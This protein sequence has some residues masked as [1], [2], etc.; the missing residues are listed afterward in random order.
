MNGGPAPFD[1][2]LAELER[3]IRALEQRMSAVEARSGSA[4]DGEASDTT[5]AELDLNAVT[6]A[7][8]PVAILSL[9]GRTLVVLGG[10][11]LLRALTESQVLTPSIGVLVG[12]IYGMTWLAIADR[13]P[14][15]AWLSAIFHGATSVMIALPLL[16]EAVTRF[17]ILGAVPA[18]WILAA[19]T[20][21][22]LA[23]AIRCRLQTLAWITIVGAIASS[24]ALT[25]ATSSVLPFAVVDIALG[26]A[27]LWIGYTVDWVWLRWPVALVTDFAVMAL[28]IGITSRTSS[29][30]PSS[31]VAVQLL[32]PGAYAL[33]VAIRTLVRGREV[34]VFEA[35]QVIVA[36]A[37]GFGGAIIVA[38]TAG[39]GGGLLVAM[40]LISGA[41]C[42]AAA[43]AFVARRQGLHQNFY[44][45]S[46]LGLV[47]ILAGSA[48]GLR[49]AAPLWALLAVF[50]AFAATRAHRVTL[51][52]HAAA[53]YLAAAAASGLLAAAATAL[54]GPP[55]TQP[56]ASVPLAI[57]F[58]AGCV[59]WLVPARVPQ[60][61]SDRRA[62]VPRV[63]IAVIV[64]LASAG[65]LVALLV[66]NA[67]DP[68]VVATIRTGALAF[69]ALAL[70]WLGGA[71]RFREAAWLV[72]PILVLGAV[73]LLAE[74]LPRSRAA[75]LFVALAVYGGA[76]IAAPRSCTTRL[77][78]L[79]IPVGT[80][81]LFITHL[82]SD[83]TIGIPDLW[84][85]AFLTNPYGG[86]NDAFRVWGPA[87][88]TAMMADMRKAYDADIQIRLPKQGVDIDAK[89]IT[90]GAGG[91][92]GRGP[93]Y[94][95]PAT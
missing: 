9:V 10:A 57:V 91:R 27:T 66:S 29:A 73:K 38:R 12:F 56:T 62:R 54:V 88:I 67:T 55:A 13:R 32:L 5:A 92:F 40:G 6:R 41:A 77:W 25:A 58:V 15:S 50:A 94:S 53:Y 20:G 87:G 21:T 86:R 72:Y 68:G 93:T 69:T 36:L 19:I 17:R 3:A 23:V 81:K 61:A 45:Y 71:A 76:L 95:V 30:S 42:Y 47:L 24:L 80:V 49:D 43:F 11:Y 89:D 74:D 70:A 33:S 39:M 64:A 52:V 59:C 90:E 34:N 22:A 31:V 2:R 63:L 4:Y 60:T 83:H 35:F 79:G 26:V 28:T 65:W 48:L 85:T 7:F 51:T 1:A 44:F 16:F 75:T 14:K 37:V 46:S 18:A 84:L 82:H 78:Q 8:D